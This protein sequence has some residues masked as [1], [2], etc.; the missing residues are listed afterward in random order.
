MNNFFSVPKKKTESPTLPG[1]LLLFPLKLTLV[2]SISDYQRYF[3]P[4]HVRQDV[5]VAPLHHFVRGQSEIQTSTAVID[6]VLAHPDPNLPPDGK[7]PLYNFINLSSS[8][9]THSYS[10]MFLPSTSRSHLQTHRK[11]TH[12]PHQRKSRLHK[13]LLLSKTNSPQTSPIRRRC[14][15]S[16]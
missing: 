15:T 12:L 1:L 7:S 2:E 3:Q 11:G 4:F 8:P 5:I 13:P 10:S 9:S 6:S 14:P 16:L